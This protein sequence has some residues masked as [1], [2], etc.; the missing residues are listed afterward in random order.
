MV[1]KIRDEA[2]E[3]AILSDQ[4]NAVRAIFSG[5]HL[6]VLTSG[7]EWMVTGDPLTPG[8]IQLRRQT[9]IGSPIDRTIPPRD[10]DGATVFVP[11][12][13]PELREFLFADVEQ[14]YQA[15]NLATLA[16]HLI[17]AP[18]D[19]DYDTTSRTLYLVM[20]DGTMGLLTMFRA[21]SVTAWTLLHTDGK[22][23]SVCLSG[24]NVYVLI[25]RNG[26]VFLEQL[27]AGLNLDCALT[28]S[29]P[30]E[31]T[32]WNGFDHLEGRMVTV[33]ADAA[34]VDPCLVSSGSITLTEPA[35]EIVAG[36]PYSHIIEPLP[37]WV[38]SGQG[39]NQGGHLR[40]VKI[41]F[42]LQKTATLKLDTG[43]GLR[44]VPFRGFGSAVL[45]Q[46]PKQFTGDITVRAMGWHSDATKPLWRIEQDI[47]LP[48]TLLSVATEISV[49]G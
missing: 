14:A 29:D 30:E 47:P 34:V 5:R 43:R 10:V 45:D 32:I 48:F 4:V 22:Y 40:P 7:A 27:E 12:N 35:N 11:R 44:E 25:V 9:R 39:G 20:A 33:L 18:V 41:T 28:G 23:Q 19:Q 1:F 16:S 36:L 21:E 17:N 31:K 37:P 3:F 24:D 13:G 26:E 6:Q 46:A 49:N 15:T 38:A 42:R 2:I 8:N